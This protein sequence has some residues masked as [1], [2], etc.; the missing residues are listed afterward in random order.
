ML[1]VERGARQDDRLRAGATLTTV[2][3]RC[4]AARCGRGNA[5]RLRAGRTGDE[6]SDPVTR[7]GSPRRARWPGGHGEPE[8]RAA[9]RHGGGRAPRRRLRRVAAG[10]P[11][12]VGRRRR[13]LPRRARRATSATST[14]S[15][16]PRACGRPTRAC[17]ATSP[18][19]ASWR[20]AAARA[21]CAR[22]L[23]TQGA[24]PVGLDLSGEMLRHAA[25]LNAATGVAVPLVQAGAERLPFADALLR[26]GLLGVRRGAVRGG[27]AS[28]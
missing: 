27:A 19:A 2:R 1:P 15:G 25:R 14:S 11:R 28:G 3:G 5:P 22:W 13:R 6:A 18:G 24:W 12:L 21:P 9:A 4:Y 17:W 23:A 26:P 10:E 20:S 16:A 8:R 7:R